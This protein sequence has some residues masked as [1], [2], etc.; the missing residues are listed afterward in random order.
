MYQSLGVNRVLLYL[1]RGATPFVKPVIQRPALY[2]QGVAIY[3]CIWLAA[4]TIAALSSSRSPGFQGICPLIRS[5]HFEVSV[6]SR[7][8]AVPRL[9]L[10][11]GLGS[12]PCDNLFLHPFVGGQST[13]NLARLSR[14][15]PP[16]G[17]FDSSVRY[18]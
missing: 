2:T 14:L 6:F 18:F 9:S 10:A 15:H 7:L 8:K 17:H 12:R 4:A 1:T 16:L 13:P 5:Y 3:I 11:G